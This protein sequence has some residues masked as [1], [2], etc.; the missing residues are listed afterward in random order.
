MLGSTTTETANLRIKTQ[1]ISSAAA[2]LGRLRGAVDGTTDAQA[3]ANTQ[4]TQGSA[5]MENLKRSAIGLATAWIGIHGAMRLKDLIV[6]ME[7]MR[8]AAAAGSLVLGNQLRAAGLSSAQALERLRAATHGM[9]GDV[10]LLQSSARAM[11]VFANS[12]ME[13]SLAFETIKTSA[14]FAT[15]AAQSFGI[16]A[17]EAFDRLITGLS[18]GSALILDD[19]GIIIDQTAIMTSG[20][21]A[22]EQKIAV[23]NQAIDQMNGYL[24]ENANSVER[25]LS[26]WTKLGVQLENFKLAGVTAQT[27]RQGFAAGIA[28]VDDPII[29]QQLRQAEFEQLGPRGSVTALLMSLGIAGTDGTLIGPPAP[30][31]VDDPFAVF[32][33]QARQNE[34]DRLRR[35]RVFEGITEE[36]QQENILRQANL[37]RIQK[38]RGPVT[39]IFGRRGPDRPI[40]DAGDEVV[41]ALEIVALKLKP[42]REEF[43]IVA[44]GRVDVPFERLPFERLPF[45]RS[46][47]EEIG[48][49]ASR[50]SAGGRA[51]MGFERGLGPLSGGGIAGFLGGMAGNAV[52]SGGTSLV[53]GAIDAAFSGVIGLF[54]DAGET[55]MKAA[56]LMNQAALASRSAIAGYL[57]DNELAA[58]LGLNAA[59]Q[60]LYGTDEDLRRRMFPALH[61]GSN[62]EVIAEF[63]RRL[64][65]GSIFNQ[66][67][68]EEQG[69]EIVAFLSALGALE[70]ALGD[71]TDALERLNRTLKLDILAAHIR[72]EYAGGAEGMRSGVGLRY[73]TQRAIRDIGNIGSYDY[74]GVGAYN[75]QVDNGSYNVG[76]QVDNGSVVI[77]PPT[78]GDNWVFSEGTSGPTPP[79]IARRTTV[80]RRSRI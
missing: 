47:I 64:E 43:G 48:R 33:Q 75:T 79:K 20:M 7:Q 55:Q 3:R 68:L 66:S 63:R 50:I 21:S 31:I 36:Q 4:F 41:E 77:T 24:D 34:I 32:S 78:G 52:L 51:I 61:A 13:A 40:I 22:S 10:A 38:I 42:F 17:T 8:G 37:R 35:E 67:N 27:A 57:G 11:T 80:K 65:E 74:S 53:T 62:A 9:V 2:E 56:Q 15:I 39:D 76:T 46:R 59:A 54:S 18:R 29:K 44:Q 14:E 72:A 49:D 73:W 26:W 28:S 30:P 25:T 23:L 5:T 6:D 71:N 69:P 58:R 45:D 12:G 70:A 16:N 19:F 60:Q 1:G